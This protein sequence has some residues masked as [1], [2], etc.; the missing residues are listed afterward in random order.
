MR[1]IFIYTC[2]IFLLFCPEL[3]GQTA[4][5]PV[6]K[7]PA[8]HTD[9][10]VEDL[11][12]RMTLDEKAGFLTGVD[13]W[14]FKGVERL[15]IPAMQ[16]TDCGHGVTV[17]LNREGNEAGSA[18][19]FPTAVGQAATW[20]RHLIRE[21]GAALGR[22][23][24]ATGS[25]MLLAPMVNMKRMPLNGRNY[26]VFSEDPVLSGELAASF[27]DGV[28]SEKVGAV[29]KAI[30]ANNQQKYQSQLN[31]RMNEQA[32]REIY[33]PSFEIA[34]EKANPW[35]VMTAYNGLNNSH[36]SENKHLLQEIL[37][38]EWKY[39]GFVVSDWRG[40][41]SLEAIVSGLDLEMPGPG[42]FLTKE[43]ILDAIENKRLS[44]NELDDKVRRILRAYIKTGLID[45]PKPVLQAEINTEKHQLLAR[46]VAEEGMV[47]LK[48][49][50]DILPLKKNINKLAVIGPN[51]AEARLGG[52]GSASVSPF[53]SVS[54]LEGIE[55]YCD[56][57]TTILFEEGAGLNG[58]FKIVESQYLIHDSNGRPKQGLKAEYFSNTQ[59]KS[60]PAVTTVDEMVDFSWGWANPKPGINKGSYS[61]RWSGRLLP[62]ETGN[63]KIGISASSGGFRLYL[64]DSLVI[65]EWDVKSAENFEADLASINK[66]VDVLLKKEVP[67][68]VQIE[69]YKRTNRNFIRFEW[70]IPGHNS[71][72]L[73]KKAAAE[74]DAVVIFAGLSNFFEGGN[75]DRSGLELPGDQNLLIEEMAKINPNTVVVLINGSPVAMPWIDEVHAVLEAY[76][77]GQEGGHAIARV[78]FGDVNPS[79]K[80]PETFPVKLSDNP[81]FTHYPGDGKKVDY[82]E[83]IFVGYRHYEKNNIKPLF[84]FGYGL[85]YTT[86]QYSDL[87]ITKENDSFVA[88]FQIKNTGDVSGAEVAQLYIRDVHASEPRPDKEL[89]NF[90]KIFLS[91]EEKKKV[92]LKMNPRDLSFFSLQKGQW[93]VEPGEFEILIGSSSKDIRLKDNIRW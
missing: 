54:P 89:K 34:I 42:K 66:T 49:D 29:I 3:V 33:L 53:Y 43:N 10:R 23:T 26:E 73:A 13:M 59:L 31:V 17:I 55:N 12:Q 24:R 36:T 58:N 35:G 28:Q 67:V 64:N 25:A 71:L 39:E 30:T 85:S 83:G 72:E 38:N 7:N 21:V 9:Q 11:L 37:K 61:V 48:N 68:G 5:V 47:L 4:G 18:S 92:S 65:D 8:Y 69:F 2:G 27:V 77:P 81:A 78:L 76:Y 80:L 90:A 56:A 52:G 62:P 74:S 51:A 63:Y 46:K 1:K 60:T 57:N 41:H 84:P 19:C 50:R 45:D 14:H 79:G 20:D 44:T 15:G 40:V 22:E 6:Y 32:L 16:V 82:E 75:N 87:K 91:P 70:E 93:I 86:F 88:T